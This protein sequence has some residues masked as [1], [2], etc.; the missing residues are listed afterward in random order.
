MKQKFFHLRLPIA[1][2]WRKNKIF[3]PLKH[4]KQQTQS[5][6]V[7]S[8]IY[9]TKM[10]IKVQSIRFWQK[11][12]NNIWS[13]SQR[14]QVCL[15]WLENTISVGITWFVGKRDVWGKRELGERSKARISSKKWSHTWNSWSMRVYS[16]PARSSD[17]KQRSYTKTPTSRQAK[18]G[19]LDSLAVT[20]TYFHRTTSC[21]HKLNQLNDISI[22][23]KTIHII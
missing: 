15:M 1:L 22:S 3:L 19:S 18:A 9:P 16:Q 2:N 4:K 17:P 11:L 10:K 5:Y 13:N 23:F 20:F 12:K 7:N 6:N 8:A 14:K 21:H